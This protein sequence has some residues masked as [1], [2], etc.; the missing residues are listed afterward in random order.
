VGERGEDGLVEQLVTQSPVDGED[1]P[2]PSEPAIYCDVRNRQQE[3]MT[4]GSRDNWVGHLE[5]RISYSRS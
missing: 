1:G 3:Q 5:A 2:A 4:N